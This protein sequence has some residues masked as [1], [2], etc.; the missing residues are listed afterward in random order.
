[1]MDRQDDQHAPD[2]KSGAPLQQPVGAPPADAQ[3]AF[4]RR[5]RLIPAI[6]GGGLLMHNLDS[7]VLANALPAMAKSLH[8]DPLTLNLAITSYLLSSAL[9]LPLSGWVAD[10]F[11]ARR[12]FM[13]AMIGFAATSLLC[14]LAQNLEQMIIG[15]LLQGAAG[16]MM[17]PVGRLVLL[18]SAPKEELVEAMAILTMPAMLGPILGPPLGGLIVTVASWREIFF[19]NIPVAIVGV[20]LTR[21]Y[22]PD[23]AEDDPGRLDLKGF[24]LAALGL[25]GLVFGFQ[26]IGRGILPLPVALG[27]AA[28]GAISAVLFVV[29]ARGRHDAILDLSV[30]KVRTFFTSVIGGLF[31]RLIAGATPFLLALMLQVGLGMSAL[32]AGLTTFISAIGALVMKTTAPP[33]LRR[34]GFRNTLIAISLLV[35]AMMASFALFTTMTPHWLILVMLLASGF[36]RSLQMTALNTL[37]FADLPA[38]KMSKA[39]ALASVGQQVGQSMGISISALLIHAVMLASGAPALNQAVIAPAFIAIALLGLIGLLFLLPLSRQAGASILRRR[40]PTGD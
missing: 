20:I 37:G 12:V 26:N 19:L 35:S 22:V 13:T 10:R 8:E 15:R 36:F 21:A 18:R 3:I 39:S 7:T 9:L 31:P 28:I 6:I 2:P 30:F 23:I 16:A 32:E 34:F 25:G 17:L 38:D 24:F 27:V 33:I 29:H 14:G 5:R 11:G 1:M 40:A 4:R